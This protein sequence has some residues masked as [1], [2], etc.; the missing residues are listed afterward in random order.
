MKTVLEMALEALES[1][2]EEKRDYMVRNNLGDPTLET[3]YKLAVSAIAAL[4]EAI[5]NQGDPVA[6]AHPRNRTFYVTANPRQLE[7][8]GFS[9]E[10]SIEIPLY[11]SAPTIPEGWQ[12]VPIEPTP[13]MLEAAGGHIFEDTYEAMLSAAPKYREGD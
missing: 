9:L 3:N 8:L 11:T 7:K 12:L 10:D 13:E 2:Q 4:K 5:K 1:M 6:I